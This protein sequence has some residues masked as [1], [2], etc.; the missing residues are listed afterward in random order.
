MDTGGSQVEIIGVRHLKGKG[1]LLWPFFPLGL[2]HRDVAAYLRM[3]LDRV[4]TA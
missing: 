3:F 2:A 4:E 1:W